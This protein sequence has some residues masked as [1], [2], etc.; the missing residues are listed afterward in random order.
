M[1]AKH[2]DSHKKHSEEAVD[3]TLETK[4]KKGSKGEALP[5]EDSVGETPE[6][7]SE[8]LAA[9]LE[10][11]LAQTKDQLLRLSADFDN[12]RK[13]TQ[14][15]KEDWARYAAQGLMEKM[16]TVIDGLDHASR[17]VEQLTPEVQK[18]VEG[19]VMIQR[20]LLDIL[21]QEGLKEI[22]ACGQP[23]D[24]NFHEAVMQMPPANGEPDNQ[25]IGVLRKGY[26]YRDRVLRPCMVQ[27]AKED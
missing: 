1:N 5:E 17:S 26:M 23:F 27:V 14:K 25:V 8:E 24:P 3:S 21:Q 9:L 18:V 19:F 10:N 7:G 6:A 2:K 22:D 11:E 12:Y 4:K 13:R 20:Q 15:E 16:L